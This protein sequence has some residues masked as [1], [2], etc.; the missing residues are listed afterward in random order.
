MGNT[1]SGRRHGDFKKYS[2]NI[3]V[4][5]QLEEEKGRLLKDEAGP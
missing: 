2:T 4:A 3:Y 5:T 1:G